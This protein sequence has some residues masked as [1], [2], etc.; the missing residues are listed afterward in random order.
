MN[1]VCVFGEEEQEL[2]F[3]GESWNSL[4]RELVGLQSIIKFSSSIL[5]SLLS[6]SEVTISVHAYLRITA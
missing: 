2:D 5:L 6:L 4:D 1:L 3:F